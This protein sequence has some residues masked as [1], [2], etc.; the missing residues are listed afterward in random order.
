MRTN[1]AE[2]AAEKVPDLHEV[3]PIQLI[4]HESVE[5]DKLSPDESIRE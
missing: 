5:H 3:V 1:E 4:T 2:D